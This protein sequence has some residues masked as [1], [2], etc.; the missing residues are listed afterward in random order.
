MFL[1]AIQGPKNGFSWHMKKGII[2]ITR[3]LNAG[4]VNNQTYNNAEYIKGEKGVE[5]SQGNK[6]MLLRLTRSEGKGAIPLASVLIRK[7]QDFCG[8]LWGGDLNYKG[9]KNKQPVIWRE[10]YISSDAQDR[11]FVYSPLAKL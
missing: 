11:N 6:N 2:K 4:S 9:A 7:S 5:K 1:K 3:L 8:S 10:F